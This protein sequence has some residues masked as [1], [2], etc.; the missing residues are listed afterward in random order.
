MPWKSAVHQYVRTRNQAELECRPDHLRDVVGDE[1]FLRLWTAKLERIREV[2][3][4]RRAEAVRQ[5]TRLRLGAVRS[6]E[7]GRTAVDLLL[8][9]TLVYRQGGRRRV[10]E[11][12]ERETVVAA[13]VRGRWEIVGVRPDHGERRPETRM[14]HA[15][16][17]RG[18]ISAHVHSIAE[19]GGAG[20]GPPL[21]RPYINRDLLVQPRAPAR[22]KPYRRELAVRYADLW[23]DTPNPEYRHFDVNCTNYVSQCLYAGGAPMTYTGK[24]ET[25]WWYRHG[26]GDAWSFSWT[27]SN[28]LRLYLSSSRTGLAAERVD[29]AEALDLGDVIVYDWDGDGRFQHSTVVTGFDE[30][31]MPLVNANT[32]SSRRRYWDYRDSYAWSERTKYAFFHILDA[33]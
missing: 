19:P 1:Q 22:N 29:S 6:D 24:R 32:V 7:D 18:A 30:N 21:G 31:G 27:V 26:Q 25:G 17:P 4:E 3:A 9:K 23:W 12:I 2:R 13:P 10:E 15:V 5:E 16:K 14:P 20:A 11:T 8:R 28:S 33:F